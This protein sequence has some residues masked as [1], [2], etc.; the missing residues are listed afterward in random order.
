MRIIDEHQFRRLCEQFQDIA[1]D[2]GVS[3]VVTKG[4]AGGFYDAHRKRIELCFGSKKYN[5]TFKDFCCT[6]FHELGHAFCDQEGIYACY[7][8]VPKTRSEKLAFRKNML[9]AEFA[10]DRYGKLLA[11]WYGYYGLGRLSSYH[12]KTSQ[13]FLRDHF[14][15]YKPLATDR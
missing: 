7:Y 1:N 2:F 12:T 14:A 9:A 15:V 8:K 13:K 10:A 5:K 3:I 6:F 11:Q 4:Q